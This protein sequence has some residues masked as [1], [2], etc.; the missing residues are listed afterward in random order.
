MK[1]SRVILLC[2]ALYV[3]LKETTLEFPTL[4]SSPLRLKVFPIFNRLMRITVQRIG[5][6]QSQAARQE[7]KTHVAHAVGSA[8]WFRSRFGWR[9]SQGLHTPVSTPASTPT[10]T[11]PTCLLAYGSS[12]TD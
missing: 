11:P 2:S 12:R 6:K 5:E 9:Q 4:H 8:S 10:P 1:S 3:W 7:G